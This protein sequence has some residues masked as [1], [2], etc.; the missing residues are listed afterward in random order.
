MVEPTVSFLQLVSEVVQQL[1]SAGRKTHSMKLA[2]IASAL[3][4]FNPFAKVLEMIRNTI[5]L[6]EE[7]EKTDVEKK[8]WCAQSMMLSWVSVFKSF[9]L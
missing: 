3:A 2:K 4:A 9:D 8:D 5:T 6:I 1:L 7:E